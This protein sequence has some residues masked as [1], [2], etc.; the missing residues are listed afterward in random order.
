VAL[1]RTRVLPASMRT[2]PSAVATKP[3]VKRT[4]RRAWAARP[5]GRKTWLEER[6][7]GS[8]EGCAGAGTQ[9]AWEMEAMARL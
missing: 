8:V 6:G 7:N 4:G 9:D 2:E 1:Q 3:V 5:S